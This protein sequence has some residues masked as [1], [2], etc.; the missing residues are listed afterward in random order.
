MTPTLHPVVEFAFAADPI[1]ASE[2]GDDRYADRLG[3][4]TPDAI[5]EYRA[6]RRRLLREAERTPAPPPGTREW[7]EHQVMLTELRAAVAADEQVQ[8]WRRA[9]YWYPERIGT[10]LS[11]VMAPVGSAVTDSRQ[12]EAL[13][14]R[15][16][17]IPA[18]LAAARANLTDDAPSLWAEM[19]ASA[20]Q[21]LSRFLGHAVPA[22]AAHL[23]PSLA[24]QITA[25]AA[26][27]VP[28]VTEFAEFSGS[29]AARASGRWQ[30]S[31]EYFDTLLR[32]LHHLPIDAAALADIGRERV[33]ADRSVLVEFAAA[34]DPERGWREQIDAVKDDHPEPADFLRTYGDAMAAVARHTAE[35]DL[36][37]LPDGEI[38]VMD[39][40]PDYLREGLPLG[41]MSTSAP[42]AA[43]LR[44]EFL[45][46]P[47][48]PD[49][50][51]ERQREHAR[52]N[53]YV[54]AT[55][56]AGHETY[57]GHHIQAVH[58]KL[59]TDR[60]S[61]LRYFRSPQF[62]E[63]WGLY[64]EDLLEETGYSVADQ[65]RLFKRRN[66]LWRALRI[67]ID[68]GL[69]TGGLG[70]D[71]A[72]ALLVDEAGMDH[73]MAAGEVRRYTRHDNPTYPS[74]YT[75]G[76]DG[77]HALRAEAQASAARAG[78]ALTLRAFHDRLLSHGSPPISLVAAVLA[79]P[80]N[81]E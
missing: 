34:L 3:D 48:D 12:P 39:S 42:F 45:I 53:C 70:I 71:E 54:F 68:V 11:A 22:H 35:A 7:L 74:S 57:P 17:E 40:V 24:A 77:F 55:S 43:G 27:A 79:G 47:A 5:D 64:V 80:R 50:P 31:A 10:A 61:M 19:G 14:G 37:A 66:A 36:L 63:G 25:A 26:A 1:A 15:L 32:D 8:V 46:T 69:H 38:C 76:R 51:P 56:I 49:A 58:H 72:V 33:A 13:L 4:V 28:A 62:V 21:G 81:P 2:A 73:H 75:L 30:C 67:V 23:P 9:P 65:V 20:A 41:V 6:T 52:D 59:G 60:G 78:T 16:G 18:Y 44:S 29:L